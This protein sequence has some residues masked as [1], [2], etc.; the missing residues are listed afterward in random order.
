MESSCCFVLYRKN[1]SKILGL[2]NAGVDL[3]SCEIV[4]GGNKNTSIKQ[5]RCK[6]GQFEIEMLQS[7]A[8]LVFW[9]IVSCSSSVPWA[10]KVTQPTVW[11]SN[12]FI[13]SRV[14]RFKMS[15]HR[16]GFV[17]RALSSVLNNFQ[18]CRLLK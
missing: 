6:L 11:I 7:L 17:S 8:T 14:N 18:S 15:V 12:V 9:L 2:Q 5:C 16:S 4:N 10:C 1:Y 13:R 3:D